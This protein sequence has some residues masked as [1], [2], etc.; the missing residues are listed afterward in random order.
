MAT[1]TNYRNRYWPAEYLIDATGTVRHIKFG[2]GDYNGTENLIRQL[3]TAANPK[4]TLPA[5][6]D[7]ADTTPQAGLTPETYLS[8]G[9]VVNYGGTGV[10]DAGD[11]EFHYPATLAD[12]T[13]ALSGP[14]SLDYQGATARADASAIELNYHAKDVYLVVGG[15]GIVTVRRDGK[16]EQIPI[17]GPP[18]SHQ[19][20]A[21]DQ[22]A[23]GHLE[24]QLSAGLQAFSFTYG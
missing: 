8:V 19:I 2:E 23:S 10:F 12:D 21:H 20:I 14:W 4:V 15:E 16:T 9:K 17:T 11:A 22:I 5:P 24:V 13:F 18:T 7:A 6:S 1:W 3:L